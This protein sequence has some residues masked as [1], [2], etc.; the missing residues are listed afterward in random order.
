MKR[1]NEREKRKRKKIERMHT[2]RCGESSGS[3][4]LR[5]LGWGKHAD[6]SSSCPRGKKTSSGKYH[7]REIPVRT[8]RRK[9]CRPSPRVARWGA[10][11]SARQVRSRE[12][13]YKVRHHQVKF[14]RNQSGH[15]AL[16]DH[17]R[18]SPKYNSMRL[19]VHRVCQCAWGWEC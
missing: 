1:E 16:L 15:A 12:A 8:F 5:T 4:P 6:H 13:R 11:G 17:E 10:R 7:R 2:Y 9:E 19:E 3:R 14:V 18:N